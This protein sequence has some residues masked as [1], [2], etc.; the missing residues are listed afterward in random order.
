MPN[1][2]VNETLCTKCNTCCTVCIMHIIDQADKDNYPKMQRAKEPYCMN[3]GHCEAFCPTQALVLDFHK[4]QKIECTPDESN[5]EPQ[6]LA[7]YLKK[8]RSIRHF[9]K[10]SVN[11]ELLLEV[12]DV[13]H[14][15]PT[16]G[17]S[18][19][20]GW[21]VIEDPSEVKNIARLTID[22]MRTIVNTDH[23]FGAYVAPIIK[24]W[25][26][27]IDFICHNAPHLL[28]VHIPDDERIKDPI[29][30]IIA[31][32]YFDVAAP[33]FGIGTCWTG[34]VSMAMNVYKPLTDAIGLP[35]GRRAAYAMLIGY[36]VYQPINIPRRNLID[37]TWKEK[38]N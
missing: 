16:G 24:M 6:R 37:V 21:L 33:A 27:G 29:D 1:I 25:D 32:S 23:P 34:F 14:Y 12:L 8:R 22:Y 17:N 36:P 20:V 3:C 15:A 9:K 7:L 30:A 26:S 11:R 13:A 5:I 35:E 4:T 2:I 18:Q 28:F 31:M 10:E 19:T 38:G